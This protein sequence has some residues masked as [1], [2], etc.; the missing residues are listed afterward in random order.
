MYVKHKK[1]CNRLGRDTETKM[2]VYFL[3]LLVTQVGRQTWVVKNPGLATLGSCFLSQA[4]EILKSPK[5]STFCHEFCSRC[6]ALT[7]NR[8]T[9]N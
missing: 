4:G 9:G 7:Q 3:N 6:E 5:A 2:S 8:I 1:K